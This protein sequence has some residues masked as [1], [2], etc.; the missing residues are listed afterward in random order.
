MKQVL[1]MRTMLSRLSGV[2]S[3]IRQLISEP[4]RRL[5]NR[6][7]LRAHRA[8]VTAEREKMR[9]YFAGLE[10]ER[11]DAER[12]AKRRDRLKLAGMSKLDRTLRERWIK[13]PSGRKI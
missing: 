7:R 10:A 9:A 6:H 4:W 1:C 8:K 12:E 11:R 2:G 13:T 5:Q 3:R